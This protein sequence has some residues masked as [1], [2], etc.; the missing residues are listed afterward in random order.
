MGRYTGKLRVFCCIFSFS[1]VLTTE[2]I[3]VV[4]VVDR[5]IVYFFGAK[6]YTLKIINAFLIEK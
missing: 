6:R 4:V 1:T 2:Y 3:P 5:R